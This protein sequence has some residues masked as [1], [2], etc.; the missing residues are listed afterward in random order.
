MKRSSLL[1]RSLAIGALAATFGGVAQAAPAE[2]RPFTF[3]GTEY[4]SQEAF[5]R[6]GHRCA[7]PNLDADEVAEIDA[8][9]ADYLSSHPGSRAFSR[10]VPVYV[11]VI[12]NGSAG[13]ISDSMISAQISVLNSAYASAGLSFSLVSTDRTSNA[14]W[15]TMTP[16]SSAE[17]AAKN[18]LRK[19]GKADLNLYLA[20]IGGGLLGWATFP[21]SYNAAPKMDGV[22]LLNQ[23]L[24]GGTAT[25]YNEGDTGTHE[26]GHWAGLYHTFQGGCNGSGDSV[27]DTPAERSAAY[28]CPT[29]RDTCRAKAGLDP[30]KNFMDYT[31]DS[32]MNTF[33]TGQV[34]RMQSQMTTY[35]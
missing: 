20:N 23:S 34:S 32:C 25:P 30:I 35:R 1:T 19:G 15:Y 14:T 22:V 27:S 9:V 10:V 4:V 26:V 12:T 33:S 5:V 2:D 21:S 31:D 3:G 18:A 24:P 13:N 8:Y 7:T 28:G 6:G 11:H 29:N 17:S 16:G